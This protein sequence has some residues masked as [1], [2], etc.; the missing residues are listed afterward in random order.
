MTPQ[1]A[2]AQA[3]ADIWPKH[4]EGSGGTGS[5]VQRS[6]DVYDPASPSDFQAFAAA[7]L[8]AGFGVYIEEQRTQ[9]ATEEPD[10]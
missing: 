10:R 2:L 8:D 5:T 4:Q 7:I 3:L 1:E 6:W 9:A